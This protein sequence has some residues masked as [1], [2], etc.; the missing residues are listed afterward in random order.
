MAITIPLASIF[1]KAG[2]K[3]GIV[4]RPER[5]G[6]SVQA[7]TNARA[8]RSAGANDAQA[9][10][11]A[12]APKVA[13]GVSYKNAIMKFYK[14]AGAKIKEVKLDPSKMAEVKSVFSKIKEDFNK[15]EFDKTNANAVVNYADARLQLDQALRT[16]GMVQDHSTARVR[17]LNTP[18]QPNNSADVR[19][20]QQNFTSN[21]INNR[22]NNIDELL[23]RAQELNAA[24]TGNGTNNQAV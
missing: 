9:R 14:E 12:T 24:N 4:R 6:P 23:R 1:Q 17:L 21:D 7:T 22:S 18:A 15:G 20:A 2:Q 13:E 16:A 11:L 5:S 8:E 10:R 19:D 3:L